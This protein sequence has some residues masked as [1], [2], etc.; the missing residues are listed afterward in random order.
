MRPGR[1]FAG[2]L[3]HLRGPAAGEDIRAA[4]FRRDM[5]KSLAMRAAATA[6][7]ND[8]R[9]TVAGLLLHSQL[10]LAE[11]AVSP[12]LTRKLK[13]VCELAGNLREQLTRPPL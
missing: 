7:E 3:C 13:I 5:E 2:E 8:L 1:S 4:L 10:A 9:S 6:I 11:P 12:A